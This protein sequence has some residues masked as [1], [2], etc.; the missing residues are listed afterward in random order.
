MREEFMAYDHIYMMI[1]HDCNFA[2]EY[3]FNEVN[4]GPIS[5]D[6][7]TKAIDILVKHSPKN[8]KK[9]L[10]VTWFGGEPSM[11]MNRIEEIIHY[12]ETTYPD[13]KF[14]YSITTNFGRFDQKVYDFIVNREDSNLMI[15]LDGNREHNK[16]RVFPNGEPTFD[17]VMNNIKKLKALNKENKL[18]AIRATFAPEDV[19][20]IYER[21]VFFKENFNDKFVMM[22]VD[23]DSWENVTYEEYKEQIIKILDYC[24]ENQTSIRPLKFFTDAITSWKY[25]KFNFRSLVKSCGQCTHQIAVDSTGALAPCHR[26]TNL[27]LSGYTNNYVVG[28][29][30]EGLFYDKISWLRSLDSFKIN[31]CEEKKCP[32]R[33]CCSFTCFSSGALCSG[34][35]SPGCAYEML[36]N[37]YHY[38]ERIIKEVLVK[39]KKYEQF[40]RISESEL[41]HIFNG[42]NKNLNNKIDEM[43]NKVDQLLDV[44]VKLCKIIA[45]REKNSADKIS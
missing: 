31:K 20:Q 7:A 6:V 27:S 3:C 8:P 32:K 35:G 2:C 44:N 26:L 41:K 42:N 10:S 40:I 19:N 33:F 5:L 24:I 30:D 25:G 1:T 18:S 37:L 13:I 14:R 43:I 22:H 36:K 9:D 17:V 21:F 28:T 11:Y 38:N 45:D 12:I 15:S 16:K 29:V 23:E 34:D 39:D 4:K